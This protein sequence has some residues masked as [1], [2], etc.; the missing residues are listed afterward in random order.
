MAQPACEAYTVLALLWGLKLHDCV[1]GCEDETCR[2]VAGT[3]KHISRSGPIWGVT[4]F[5]TLVTLFRS[6]SSY[7]ST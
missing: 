1:R 3:H 5:F 4:Q 7:T 2:Q 6:V